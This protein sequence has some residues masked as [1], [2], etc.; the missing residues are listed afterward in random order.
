MPNL[1]FIHLVVVLFFVTNIDNIALLFSFLALPTSRRGI[2]ILAYLMSVLILFGILIVILITTRQLF[3][4]QYFR[5]I[6]LIPVGLGIFKLVFTYHET[7]GYGVKDKLLKDIIVNPYEQFMINLSSQFAVSGDSLALFLPI[8]LKCQV[9][10]V[11]IFGV[12]VLV[13]AAGVSVAS[14]FIRKFINLRWLEN[15]SSR[16]MP[17]VL[18]VIGIYILFF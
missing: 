9:R 8:L 10:E 16:L 17:W 4:A 14:A 7:L 5:Y 11:T 3:A 15:F 6:G 2:V 13:L 1:V 18:I 12:T